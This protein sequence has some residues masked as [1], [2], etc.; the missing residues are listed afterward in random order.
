MHKRCRTWCERAVAWKILLVVWF[1]A[2][3]VPSSLLGRACRGYAS[4]ENHFVPC[5]LAIVLALAYSRLRR[6]KS[7]A[8]IWTQRYAIGFFGHAAA[9][10]MKRWVLAVCLADSTTLDTLY[11]LSDSAAATTYV[12]CQFCLAWVSVLRLQWMAQ[13]RQAWQAAQIAR[14][15]GVFAV[16]SGLLLSVLHIDHSHAEHIRFVVYPVYFAGLAL[17]CAFQVRV[18]TALLQAG[19]IALLEAR[20]TGQPSEQVRAANLTAIAVALSSAT[21]LLMCASL[22]TDEASPPPVLSLQWWVGWALLLLDLSTDVLLALVCSGLIT[23]AADQE[24]NFKLA[25]DL[26]EAARRE[27][28][29][30]T[31]REAASA[32][33]G[34]AVS[35]AA[36]FIPLRRK[37]PRATL[38]RRREALPL[39]LLGGASSAPRAHTYRG[40]IG[41]CTCCHRLVC[42]LGAM[43]TLWLRCVPFALVA[44]RSPREVAK[45]ERVV[46][47]VL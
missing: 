24:R 5:F 16:L 37:G 33:T 11:A 22:I 46:C 2:V 29:L 28:I 35:L 15:T 30:S 38:G 40:P 27:K 4:K 26:V 42:T 19:R 36:L 20:R 10:L 39:H 23:A 7:R 17:F 21:T 12:W 41:W 34:P 14:I 9:M 44:R 3:V 13:P 6:L 47:G 43:P 25:G 45:S 32:V 31:L 8:S 1:A 18:V